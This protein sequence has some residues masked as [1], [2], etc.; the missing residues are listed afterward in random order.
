[1]IN[2]PEPVV[3]LTD[4]QQKQ[5]YVFQS[6]LTNLQTETSIANK[7]LAERKEET[8]KVITERK[9]NEEACDAIK[10]EIAKLEPKLKELSK[11]VEEKEVL[12][13]KHAKA[14]VKLD[15]AVI[16][17]TEEIETHNKKMTLAQAAHDK[18]DKDLDVKAKKIEGDREQVEHAKKMLK[19]AAESI[20]WK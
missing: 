20:T 10:R 15:K 12:L 2:S 13:D 4:E 17:K 9:Y 8:V 7:I 18:R 11:A 16:D 1:M 6:R 5:L 14:H 19:V 3:T